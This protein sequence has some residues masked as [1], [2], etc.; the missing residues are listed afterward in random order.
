M[1]ARAEPPRRHGAAE[2]VHRG[3]EEVLYSVRHPA[4]TVLSARDHADGEAGQQ[5]ENKHG[6]QHRTQGETGKQE[7]KTKL[8]KEKQQE[9]K[10]AQKQAVPVE[11]HNLIS[12]S[13]L[14]Q[15]F[16]QILFTF[17]LK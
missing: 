13:V 11:I 3:V 1:A 2:G 9:G 7:R 10:S 8:K 12:Y 15:N 5:Q 16:Y 17:T 6:G 14:Q 4:Q